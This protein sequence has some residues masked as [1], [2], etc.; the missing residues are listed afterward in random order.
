V[1]PLSTIRSV[2]EHRVNETITAAKVL[3]V[4]PDGSA[5]A[6]MPTVVALGIAR[7][8]GLD[9]VEVGPGVVPTVKILSYSKMR[10]EQSVKDRAARKTRSQTV[11]KEMKFRPQIDVHD[12]ETKV[13]H[14]R[15]FLKDGHKVKVTVMFKGRQQGR[16]EGGV[17][18]LQQLVETL[19]GV[20]YLEGPLVQDGRDLF[21]TFIPG[22]KITK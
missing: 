17:K 3:L 10:Y 9:L 11:V 12:F 5:V 6:E 18:I 1:V 4:K 7:E 19:N 8:N 13:G 16:P 21:A 22:V 14:I 20:A 15:K 2:A